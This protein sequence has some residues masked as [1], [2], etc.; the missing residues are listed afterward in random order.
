VSCPC[1]TAA[2][3]QS[4]PRHGRMACATSSAPGP[5]SA[6]RC[7]SNQAPTGSERRTRNRAVAAARFALHVIDVAIAPRARRVR[8]RR[9]RPGAPR[10][11][12]PSTS[13]PGSPT[14]AESS[15][16]SVDT[17]SGERLGLRAG[18]CRSPARC[19]PP[20]RGRGQAGPVAEVHPP[21]CPRSLQA[22]V[23][24]G[25][26]PPGGRLTPRAT[27]PAA[28]P[29]RTPSTGGERT[30]PPRCPRGRSPPARRAPTARAP[31]PAS[32]PPRRGRPAG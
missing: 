7:N 12:V 11:G 15:A 29:C 17:A 13:R 25:A 2:R 6:A 21:L 23:H 30:D 9:C 10:G 16:W 5:P 20:R 26:W 18:R 31:A 4:P 27:G 24:R 14:P 1:G 28:S 22:T 8:F 3:E 32:G 19:T